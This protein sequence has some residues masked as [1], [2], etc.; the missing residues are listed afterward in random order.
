MN[1]ETAVYFAAGAVVLMA[2][3]LAAVLSMI[4]ID[5]LTIWPRRSPGVRYWV[6]PSVIDLEGRVR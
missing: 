4:V 1:A 3:M 6:H 5:W 2:L